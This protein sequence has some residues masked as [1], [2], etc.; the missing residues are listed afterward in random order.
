MLPGS[1]RAAWLCA[2][3]AAPGRHRMQGVGCEW[4]RDK[5]PCL[6]DLKKVA[7]SSPVLVVLLPTSDAAHAAAGAMLPAAGTQWNH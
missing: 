4:V 3:A 1:V 2:Q 5:R 7:C 6:Q